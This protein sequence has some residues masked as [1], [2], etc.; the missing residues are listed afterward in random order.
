M[1][2][3]LR[4]FRSRCL[5]CLPVMLLV[6]LAGCGVFS[7]KETSGRQESPG[8]GSGVS[9]HLSIVRRDGRP[10]AVLTLA[11]NSE[12]PIVVDR[13]LVFFVVITFFDRAGKPVT[14]EWAAEA[15]SPSELDFRKRFVEI[16][17]GGALER[18]ID[19]RGQMKEFEV[20]HGV[21]PGVAAV[22]RYEA[23]SVLPR[24]PRPVRM[25]V[26]YG[27]RYYTATDVALYTGLGGDAPDIFAEH[28]KAY[29]ALPP[30]TFRP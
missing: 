24:G 13:E 21:G 1:R 5:V 30:G 27:T 23:F 10:V 6:I 14:P 26:E 2:V 25:D 12:R 22:T 19:L 17:V 9:L 29:T 11:N 20:G 7:D 15:P 28:L 8:G 16:P 18:E 4:K 3:D